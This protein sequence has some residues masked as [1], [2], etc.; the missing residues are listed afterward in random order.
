MKYIIE[1]RLLACGVAQSGQY[2]TTHHKVLQN[3]LY[4]TNKPGLSCSKLTMSFVNDSLKFT[5]SDTQIC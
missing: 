3:N 2:F 1:K 5:A 4:R